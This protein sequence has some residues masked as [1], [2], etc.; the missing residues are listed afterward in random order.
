[1]LVVQ[2]GDA[3]WLSSGVWRYRYPS[4]DAYQAAVY[5]AAAAGRPLPTPVSITVEQ[6]DGFGVAV[7]S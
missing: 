7:G 5:V 3:I 1:M 2:V 4:W 6:L